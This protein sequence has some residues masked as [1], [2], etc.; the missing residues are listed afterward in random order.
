VLDTD[1][2]AR[3]TLTR[4]VDPAGTTTNTFD[5]ANRL[6]SSTDANGAIVGY[7]Y[8][9][10]G[11][12]KSIVY[13][14]NKVVSYT[15][16]EL[17]RMATAKIEWL[18]K[19]RSFTYDDAGRLTNATQFNG[20]NT[21]YGFDDANRLTSVVHSLGGS[22]MAGYQYQ[23]DPNGN[24]T[25][26]TISPEPIKPGGLIN[27]TI[28]YTYNAQRNR[29]ESTTGNT[30]TYDNEGQQTAKNSTA[31]TFDFAHRLTGVGTATAYVYDGVGNRLRA[32]RNGVV[33]RYVYDATGNLLA[34]ADG[35]GNITRY[36]IYAKGLAAMV[37]ADGQLYSY[38]FDG[39]GN[40]IALTNGSRQVVNTYAY[41]PYGRVLGKQEALAQPFKFAG[42]VGIMDEGSDLYYMRARYYDAGTGRFIS[43]DPAGFV[44]GPNLYAYVGGNPI[45]AVDPTGQFGITT[46]IGAI[47]G[48]TGAALGTLA[49]GGSAVDVVI[50]TFAGAAM[51]AAVGTVAP[52]L[53]AAAGRGAA[54][55]VNGLIGFTSNTAAQSAQIALHPNL[56]ANDYSLASA[57][58]SGVI[59]GV[60][61]PLKPIA[62]ATAT[63]LG[64]TVFD[65]A[66]GP[67]YEKFLRPA[68]RY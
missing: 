63:T 46:I 19:T 44:D 35:A 47:S 40:T 7:T 1:Y 54:I 56:K 4:M 24:R 8:D 22:P 29:L 2:A 6:S 37:T 48:G 13:P 50:G 27:N 61:S 62:N 11:N 52:H 43:E 66:K 17:N 67:I 64:G 57:I 51:G 53:A 9:A 30:F 10:A 18:N 14:G 38:H 5:A 33:T 3:G 42:Q 12:V 58:A 31:Y 59:G 32:T 26:I 16:D 36:Y 21:A 15:Y 55:A 20:A 45:M 34:E 23:L 68:K 60:A 39:S 49:Q 41:A 25:R 65:A 28:A